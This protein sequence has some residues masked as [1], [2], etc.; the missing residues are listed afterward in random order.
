MIVLHQF[1]DINW[2]KGQINSNFHN[3]LAWDN[4]KIAHT[5]WPTVVLNV[6]TKEEERLAI[7]G[8]F[9]L[10]MNRVGNSEIKAGKKRISINEHACVMTNKGQYY[11]FVV[12]NKATTPQTETLNIHFGEKL[13]SDAQKVLLNNDKE[14]L[15][16]PFASQNEELIPIKTIFKTAEL[17]GLVN[18]LLHS[19]FGNNIMNDENAFALLQHLFNENAK[20]FHQ[21]KALQDLK[22]STRQE[23]TDRVWKAVDFMH[24]NFNRPITL[25]LIAEIG[26]MSKFHFSRTFKMVL[27]CSP[28]QYLNRLKVNKATEMYSSGKW[29]LQEIGEEIGI[30]HASSV[31]RIIFKHLGK[32][33]SRL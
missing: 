31:S 29:T 10:F 14:L 27:G 6:K 32:Y 8:P 3:R 28:Y 22:K 33:P 30:E 23:L 15:D 26:C 11:D 16:D 25:D 9:S 7:K 4:T 5:G 1:P 24:V 19:N 2:L 18:N 12:N 17:K 21:I 13:Y 20:K